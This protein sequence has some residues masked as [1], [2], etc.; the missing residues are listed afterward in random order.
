MSD[1]TLGK[2]PSWLAHWFDRLV[3]GAPVLPVLAVAAVTVFFGLYVK[4]FKLDASSDSI[5]LENDRD[6]RYYNDTR[7]I[8]GSDDYVIV[9]VTPTGDLFADETLKALSE[10]TAELDA[11]QNVSS[12]TSILNVPLFH[13]PNV[14]LLQLATGYKTL[15][16]PDTDREKAR[17]ELTESPF[18]RD[19]LIS[20]DGA[21][22]ALQVNFAPPDEEYTRLY[23]RRTELRDKRIA[24]GLTAEEQEELAAISKEYDRRRVESI[25]ERANDIE[26]IR[27]LMRKYASLGELYLGGVPMIMVDIIDYV[28]SDIVTFGIGVVAF[29]LIMLAILFRGLRWIVLPSLT[30]VLTVLI[31][32][33][34]LGYTEWHTTIVTSNF[35][36]LLLVMTM[37]MCIHLAVRFR[38][39]YAGHPDLD[40]REIMV[41]SVRQ[42]A[43]PCFYTVTTTIAGFGSL[44][45][46]QI[47]PV[48]D[49]GF[50]MAMGLSLAYLMCFIFFPALVMFFPKGKVP[51]RKFAELRQSSMT[52]FAR[53]TERHG[54]LIAAASVVLFVVCVLGSTRLKV[55]NRFIDYF[56]ENTM[57]YKGMTK[58]DERLGGTT[59]LE[60]V[61]AAEGKD[62]WLDVN[63][64]ERLKAVHDWLDNLP[65]TGKVISPVTLLRILEGINGGK[66]VTQPILNLAV[67][68][69]PEEIAREVVRP[70][71]S[72]D[73]DQVRFAMRVR[74]SS[75]DLNRKELL[76]RLAAYFEN[77]APLEKGEVPRPT[78]MFVLY[79]NM[80]QSL[81]NSQILT[82]GVVF[83]A[84]WLMFLVLFRSAWLA[85]IAI[86]PNILPVFMVLGTLGWSGIPLDIMT[87]MTAAITF[88]MAVDFAIHYIHRFKFEF[89]K[90]RDYKAAMYRCHN[91]IGSAIYYTSITVIVGFSVLMASNFIPTIYFG[92][93]TGLAMVVA[94]LASITLLPYLLISWKP[95][96]PGAQPATQA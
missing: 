18:Y 61:I 33:G 84:I 59:P 88:G 11:I 13:S 35:T 91:S 53:V 42:L 66:P 36:S 39:I 7:D 77:E 25:N 73:F 24:E 93:F 94:F 63:R 62:Y 56:R 20:P 28:E 96:G 76:A 57:I 45:A 55:E 23:H 74:E 52:V 49:F 34:Y 82:I 40:K 15:L 41:L 72:A 37:A 75:K 87:I 9:T 8:F 95:F 21:T 26:Q 44:I 78:G 81:Y 5:V 17:K 85:T 80:L 54:G 83:A 47:R 43:I 12:V 65:E 64:L 90:D 4:D 19:H 3:L 6:L 30:S 31:M 68:R 51:P 48:M 27:S 29:M 58:I 1:L 22:T 71:A 69:V 86:I 89:A 67:S 2:R 46:S 70:Y 14:P 92:L 79:N 60:I 10:L 50:M 16:M 38:E 32:M